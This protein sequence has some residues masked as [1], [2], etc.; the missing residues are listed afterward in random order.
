LNENDFFVKNKNVLF[1]VDDY[2]HIIE[3]KNKK[4]PITIENDSSDKLSVH[5]IEELDNFLGEKD[6]NSDVS[7]KEMQDIQEETLEFFNFKNNS[8]SLKSDSSCSSRT[9]YTTNPEITT[10]NQDNIVGDGGGNSEREE[11]DEDDADP[12][13]D[14]AYAYRDDYRSDM[15]D[16]KVEEEEWEDEDDDDDDEEYDEDEI[17]NAVL[18]KFPIELICME[19][20][21]NTLDNYILDEIEDDESKWFS[22]LF[23]I[24]MTLITYQKIF[25]FTHN[26]L[27]TNNIMYITTDQPFLYYYYNK[28]Y[29][30]VP[31]HGKIFKIIDFGRSIFKVRNNTFCSNSFKKGENAATQY[32][33]EPYFDDTKPRIEPNY[34]FDL[35]RLACSIFDYIVEDMDEIQDLENCNPIVKLITEWCLDD[36]G[37]H[38]L[39]KKN[40]GERYPDFKLYKMIARHVHNHTPD[41]QLQRNE[42]MSF[43]ITQKEFLLLSK[44]NNIK[45]FMNIDDLI[46]I[47]K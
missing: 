20:C 22:M 28:K 18:P 7:L 19:H 16:E 21:E 30:K 43:R 8:I 45:S 10:L 24:I 27:H 42:F 40:G 12:V 26:D 14:D 15:G 35:C 11:R 39:Y 9:S 25:S 37:I 33:V 31:T 47:C 46:E 6:I 36:R 32:N 38:L 34:S 3:C 41:A 44:K 1:K 17:I 5:S 13:K 23:Q 4:V 29:Y 2:S